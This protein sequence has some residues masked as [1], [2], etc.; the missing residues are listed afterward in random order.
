MPVKDQDRTNRHAS[1]GL[2]GEMDFWFG[3][4][5][6]LPHQFSVSPQPSRRA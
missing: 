2:K 4:T 6:I 1:C 3:V 5:R